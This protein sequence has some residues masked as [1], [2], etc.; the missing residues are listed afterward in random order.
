M[1]DEYLIEVL[2]KSGFVQIDG[3]LKNMRVIQYGT[4]AYDWYYNGWRITYPNM[5]FI[6]IVMVSPPAG[7]Y[8]SGWSYDICNGIADY[9]S[10]QFFSFTTSEVSGVGFNVDYVVLAPMPDV[11]ISPPQYGVVLQDEN[12][13][14]VFSSAEKY[15]AIDMI[16]S[17]STLFPGYTSYVDVAL[18]AIPFGKRYFSVNSHFTES[19]YGLATSGIWLINQSAVRIGQLGWW[20]TGIRSYGEPMQTLIGYFNP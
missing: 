20:G 17:I 10:F 15:M 5:G 12:N 19:G 6:P 18:P 16:H 1:T 8:G 13:S 7:T 3:T 2:N 4:V 11:L 14:I 9:T